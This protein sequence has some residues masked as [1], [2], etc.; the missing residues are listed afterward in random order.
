MHGRFFGTQRDLRTRY[1]EADPERARREIAIFEGPDLDGMTFTSRT[2]RD[3]RKRA[4]FTEA[5]CEQ[6]D[7]WGTTPRRPGSGAGDAG[8]PAASARR[9]PCASVMRLQAAVT[10][11][12]ADDPEP[13][14][15][16]GRMTGCPACAGWGDTPLTDDPIR[17]RHQ[18]L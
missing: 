4:S 10:C 12:E 11:T 16:V 9:G 1:L 6:V 14:Y 15:E 8:G 17:K 18:N 13:Q 5:E 3:L 2:E 7:R